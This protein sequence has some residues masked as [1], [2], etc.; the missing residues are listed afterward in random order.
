MHEINFDGIPSTHWSCNAI[1]C[2][3]CWT[4]FLESAKQCLALGVTQQDVY[5]D[6]APIITTSSAT[7]TTS[8]TRASTTSSAESWLARFEAEVAAFLGKEAALWV[9]S[10]VMAQGN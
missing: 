9:P 8:T 3:Y 5:G 7:S 1:H 2:R 6:F 10:G 4:F